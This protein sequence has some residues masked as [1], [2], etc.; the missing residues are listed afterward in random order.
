MK[1]SIWPAGSP[2]QYSR[3]PHRDR[4]VLVRDASRDV[5]KIGVSYGGPDSDRRDGEI[6]VIPPLKNCSPLTSCLIKCIA[7]HNDARTSMLLHRIH[8]PLTYL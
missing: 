4:P 2:M 1:G 6:R 8:K 3:L 7:R 5:H